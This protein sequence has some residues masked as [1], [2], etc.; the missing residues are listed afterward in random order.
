MA[1]KTFLTHSRAWLFSCMRI[2]GASAD[3]EPLPW[4]AG[5]WFMRL[6]LARLLGVRL[7]T[8]PRACWTE[9]R[10]VVL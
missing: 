8:G 3:W 7:T 2:G 1:V 10:K 5:Q 4:S 9:T 6:H